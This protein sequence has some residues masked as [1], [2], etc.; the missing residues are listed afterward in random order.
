[1]KPVTDR[2]RIRMAARFSRD[3]ADGALEAVRAARVRC[4]TAG[5]ELV[6]ALYALRAAK[7]YD[8]TVSEII[9]A[10]RGRYNPPRSREDRTKF[11]RDYIL[12]SLHRGIFVVVE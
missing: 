1:M 12:T 7:Q 6:R 5:Q 8:P 9:D 4:L 10:V 2:T 3:S 11:F